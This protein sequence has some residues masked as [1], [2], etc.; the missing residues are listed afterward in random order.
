[1]CGEAAAE[2]QILLSGS[3]TTLFSPLA[4]IR[5]VVWR[6]RKR[7]RCRRFYWSHRVRT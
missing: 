3:I 6:K 2:E 1:M 5:F 4:G 7:K